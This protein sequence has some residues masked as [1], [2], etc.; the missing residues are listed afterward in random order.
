[1]RSDVA[2]PS[3][4]SSFDW[5]TQ[6]LRAYLLLTKPRIILLF[7]LTG[8]TSLFL[9]GSIASD[10]ARVFFLFCGICLVGGSANSFNQYFDRDIDSQMERTRKKRPLPQG[11]IQPFEAL[12]FASVIGLL[13]NWLLLFYGSYEALFWGIFT[14]GFYVGIYTLWLKRKTPYNIVIG[15]AA[16]ATAPLIAWAAA[17]GSSLSWQPWVLFLIVFLW[18][19]PHFWALALCVKD[20]YAGVSV[21]MLPVVAG[22]SVTKKQIFGYSLLLV[23]VTFFLLFGERVG[24]IYLV[25]ALVLGIEFLRRAYLVFRLKPN[26]DEIV[27]SSRRLFGYSIVYLF[28]L[29]VVL[30]IDAVAAEP[31]PKELL[32]VGFKEHLGQKID[33]SLTF[34]DEQGK[35]ISLSSKFDGKRPVALFLMYY[36]CPNLCGLFMNGVVESFKKLDWTPGEQFQIVTVSIDPREDFEIADEKKKSVLESYGRN[37]PNVEQGWSFWTTAGI[38]KTG[39][40]ID[41]MA[42]SNVK[43]LANQVGF[44]YKYDKEQGQYAH[45]AGIVILT[46]EGRIS[47]Y[48]YG[49]DFKPKDVKLALVEAGGNKIGSIIDRFML[50]CYNYDPKT[51]KYSLYAMNLMRVA[52][53]VTSVLIAAMILYWRRKTSIT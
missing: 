21:P 45:V 44:G 13:G 35:E 2:D 9:E 4:F 22:V 28:L 25:A 12:I 33:T 42:N 6:R 41:P 34:T 31:T 15:G 3:E 39:T 1:M 5:I 43:T 27:K 23:P 40:K 18:T 36:G 30:M 20:E 26:S 50:F 47:R 8:L 10:S 38:E 19:P 49:I 32:E 51:K 16:G 46:P 17:A 11:A 7:G 37:G 48:L 53:G 14:I 52:G 24:L 29:Y